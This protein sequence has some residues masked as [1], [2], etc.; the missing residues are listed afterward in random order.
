MLIT[1][2]FTD[3][4]PFQDLL[5]SSTFFSFLLESKLTDVDELKIQP[6]PN[7]F[8]EYVRLSVGKPNKILIDAIY[9]KIDNLYSELLQAVDE[10]SINNTE[11][12]E[13]GAFGQDYVCNW[14]NTLRYNELVKKLDWIKKIWDMEI[15]EFFEE[16]NPIKYELQKNRV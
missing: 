12:R 1:P 7:H 14:E 10:E 8:E 9:T 6:I 3:L 2:Q 4:Y 13:E 11:E 16:P 15:W 5:Q